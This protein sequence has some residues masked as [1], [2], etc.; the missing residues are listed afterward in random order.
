[1]KNLFVIIQ[2][3]FRFVKLSIVVILLIII[4]VTIIIVVIIL[5]II[6]V[7]HNRHLQQI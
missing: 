1:M 7:F 5:I 2:R 6:F 4:I 3:D